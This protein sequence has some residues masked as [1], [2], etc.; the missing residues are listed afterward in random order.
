[1]KAKK[2]LGQNFLKVGNESAGVICAIQNAANLSTSDTVVEIGPG[3]GILTEA[4]LQSAEK[5]FAIEKDAELVKFLEKKFA[6]EISTG[7]LKLIHNDALN[8][9]ITHYKLKA[10]NY[11]LAA[12]IP[13]YITGQILRKFLST[14]HKP[15]RMVLML[16]KE[17]A[18]RVVASDKKESILSISVKVYGTPRIVRSVPREMFSPRPK[19]DS[20]IIAIENISSQFLSKVEEKKFFDIL[21]AGFAHKRKMLKSNIAAQ[22]KNKPETTAWEDV[23]KECAINEDARAE[24][25][26]VNNWICLT[27]KL[28]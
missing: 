4:L 5:V 15:E 2:S 27:K 9:D 23:C 1:M 8:F 12:N 17:V 10:M 3:K 16:Q 19:V 14:E 26:S 18:E 7:K 21:H 13:Y 6:G 24:T 25:L 20:A 22:L 11:K 28:T